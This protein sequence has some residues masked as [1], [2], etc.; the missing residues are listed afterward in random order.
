M[1]K[2]REGS[3]TT[4]CKLTFDSHITF[5]MHLLSHSF[6]WNCLPSSPVLIMPLCSAFLDFLEAYAKIGN[7]YDFSVVVVIHCF[8]RGLIKLNERRLL[9]EIEKL[10]E[11]L[12]DQSR[13]CKEHESQMLDLKARFKFF[14]TG[15]LGSRI[16]FKVWLQHMPSTYCRMLLVP[17]KT[18]TFKPVKFAL[19]KLTSTIFKRFFKKI[20][21]FSA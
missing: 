21:R 13:T 2:M 8:W 3:M 18:F 7:K 11:K 5:N 19:V 6:T 16:N 17:E 12:N 9:E 1:A 20:L 10:K 15:N 4:L 14:L